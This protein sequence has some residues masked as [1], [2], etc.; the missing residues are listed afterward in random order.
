[1]KQIDFIGIGAARSG[2]SWIANVLREHTQICVSE[3]KE[4]RYFNRNELPLGRDRGRENPNFDKGLDW[5]LAHFRH[6]RNGQLIGEYTPAYLFDEAAPIAIKDRFPNAKLIVSLRN[7]VDRAYSHYWLK[8][9]RDILKT[10][11]PKQLNQSSETLSFEDML[12]LE[13]EYLE[14]GKYPKDLAFFKAGLYAEHLKWYFERFSRDHFCIFLLED[15]MKDPRAILAEVCRFLGVNDEFSFTGLNTKMNSHTRVSLAS[16]T[17]MR[18][19]PHP[20]HDAA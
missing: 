12:K 17:R 2:T 11:L 14:Q 16:A 1:M 13:E 5:Y 10:R 6:A 19:L 8:A 3:P 4:L 7:P 9:D 20:R 15:F 18:L